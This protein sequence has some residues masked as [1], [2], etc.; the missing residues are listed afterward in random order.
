MLRSSEKPV[1]SIDEL[2]HNKLKNVS[3]TNSE[4]GAAFDTSELYPYEANDTV[5]PERKLK[6]QTKGF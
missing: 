2:G 1:I 4:R 3:D 6:I 5:S